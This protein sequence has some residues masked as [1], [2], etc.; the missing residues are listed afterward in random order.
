M[1]SHVAAEFSGERLAG[2]VERFAAEHVV[3][4]RGFCPP[5]LLP[6]VRD[7]AF[8]IMDR[9]GVA[10]DLVLEITDGTPRHMTTVGQPVV[11]EHGRLIH[12][13][14]FAPAMREFI[15]AVVGEEV[16]ICPYPGEHYVVSRL[17]R[18]GTRMGGIGMTTRTGSC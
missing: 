15:S 4:L 2:L 7:E 12:S 5:G 14:Y 6:A 3:P 18:S 11:K 13:L 1:R 10:R 9:F 17:G 8:S 16:F